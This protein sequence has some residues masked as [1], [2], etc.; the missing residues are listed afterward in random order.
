MNE[1]C[2]SA[3][4]ETSKKKG[5]DYIK[6]FSAFDFSKEITQSKPNYPNEES[7]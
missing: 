2:I 1:E 6:K 3:F 4:Y 7:K 5:L